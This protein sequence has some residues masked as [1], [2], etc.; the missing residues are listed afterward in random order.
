MLL[1]RIFSFFIILFS[2]VNAAYSYSETDFNQCL[3]GIKQSPIIL[4]APEDSLRNWCDCVLKRTVDEGKDD[5]E[6]AARCGRLHFK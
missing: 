4:G 2:L 6:S 1:K 5:A 3:S